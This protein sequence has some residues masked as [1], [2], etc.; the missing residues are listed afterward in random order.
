[1]L[2]LVALL[3]APQAAVVASVREP[4]CSFH[5]APASSTTWSPPL[6]RIISF[7]A[8]DI[9]LRDA[10]DRLQAQ[11]R[12]HLSYSGES[13]P[14]DR[15]VCLTLDSVQVGDVLTILLQGT[16]VI[17][18]V[19]AADYVVLTPPAGP[20]VAAA[21]PIMLDRIVVTGSM[22][23]A[24]R[25]P[26]PVALDVVNGRDLSQQ[27]VTNLAEALSAQV[28]GEFL[29]ASSPTSLLSQYGSIRGASSLGL[30]Y[31]KV[32]IDGIEVA[33]P[34][35][36][37]R[38]SPDAIDR[39]EVIRGPQG[40]AL[41]G[42]DAI[43]GITNIVSRQDN[44]ADE[45]RVRWQSDVGAAASDFVANPTLRQ[46]HAFAVRTGSSTGSAGLNLGYASDGAFVP[47]AYAR[48]FSALGNARAV[49]SQLI[50]TGIARF[51][52]EEAASPVS[53]VLLDSVA[54][55]GHAGLRVTAPGT[56]SVMEYTAGT[57]LKYMPS[58]NWKH[59]FTAGVDGY[60]LS[61]IPDNGAPLPSAA[62]SALL[63]AR[64]SA[65]RATLRASSMRSIEMSPGMSADVTVAAEQSALRQSI[66]TDGPHAVRSQGSRGPGSGRTYTTPE[67]PDLVD[68]RNTSALSGMV[69][70]TVFD[71]FF[72]SGGLRLESATDVGSTT[73]PMLGGAWVNDFGPAT[74]KLRAAYGKGVR[75][76][77][78]TARET[79]YQS[80]RAESAPLT[81][82]P[83][84]Q[85]GVEGGLDLIV[86]Q[87]LTLSATRFDQ[88]ASG[89]I[90]RV[91]M[92]H[93]TSTAPPTGYGPGNP[94][95]RQMYYQL[96]NVG[97][98]TNRGWEFSGA[99]RTGPFR[100]SGTLSLVDSRV[101]SLSPGYT[102]DLQAGDRML[103]VPARTMS[104]TTQFVSG[105]WASSFT[106]YGASDW[107]NYDRLALAEAFAGTT[108]TSSNLVGVPL[109]NYWRTYNGVTHARASVTFYV[110]RGLGWTLSGDNLFDRQT[111]EPD[112]VTVLP[113]RTISLG[114]KAQF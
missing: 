83:E 95:P 49:G 77:Q 2:A 38:L 66:T 48:S 82:Q 93:D 111:G 84:E 67:G 56:Q 33:N 13:L 91:A 3:A 18:V 98:A 90:Q 16:G 106:V 7:H 9:S 14:L 42:G 26:L 52:G 87:A 1:M 94:P 80:Q 64:G 68:W 10:L 27:S 20:V 99:L 105:R 55:A 6:D 37:T 51:F 34:L 17:P 4:V 108:Q 29:W 65:M 101:K 73:L 113:G 71:Q 81:L 53:P 76:P 110:R 74:L 85:H 97:E 11:A 30:S 31:P 107:I 72:V 96:E 61:G 104:I 32:Y 79:M 69:S 15:Q 8:A 57:T 92:T 112:N 46:N 89:L 109:R 114:L 41:Y 12:I 19:T 59:T 43:S 22:S 60:T 70:A 24:S 36:I 23:G 100:V 25:R 40:A 78:T 21:N 102:G 103:E 28:P 5:E 58:V 88:T 35:L 47:G 39:I 63:A 62:D 44:G 86:A 45:P 54:S 75:W 50:W